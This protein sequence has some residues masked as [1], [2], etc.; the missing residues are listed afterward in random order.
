MH[1]QGFPLVAFAGA[2]VAGDVNVGQKMH[3]HADNAIA[4]AGLAAPALDVEAEATG[5]VASGPG[6]TGGGKQFPNRGEQSGVGGR[7][8]ARRTPDGALVDGNH[9]VQCFQPQNLLMGSRALG[10]A[11]QCPRA[12]RIQG[13]VDKGGFARTTDPGD[14]GKQADGNPGMDRL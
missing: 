9:L 3:F 2:D 12:G 10:A 5:I 13:V 4:F 1:I 14:A 6:F 7:V 11:H 8:A